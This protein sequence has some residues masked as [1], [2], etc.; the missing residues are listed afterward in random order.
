MMLPKF[1]ESVFVIYLY[2][3]IMMIDISPLFE[4]KRPAISK[5]QFFTGLFLILI[6]I[7]SQYIFPVGGFLY[8][9]IIIYGLPIIIA[10]LFLGRIIAKNAFKNNSKALVQGLAYWGL[11]A[12]AGY[13]AQIIIV[14]WLSGI[15]PGSLALLDR[16]NPRIPAD[17]S[18][19]WAMIPISIFIVGP[20]EEYIFRGFIFGGFLE[21][22]GRKYWFF[23]ALVSSIIFAA[24]HLYYL[25]AFGIA[26]A[27]FFVGIVFVGL[28]LSITYYISKGNLL[29]PVLLHGIFDATGFLSVALQNDSGIN[30][31]VLLA[32][33]GIFIA[34]LLFLKYLAEKIKKAGPAPLCE[35]C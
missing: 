29:V 28:A 11:F 31:Q 35:N 19:L 16:A 17:P 7:Y 15:N 34:I 5:S 2:G 21:T 8:R 18:M 25:T 24:V 22:F 26:S 4:T 32:G 3:K 30:F 10:S 6:L 13:I 27:I 9:M 1:I 14:N 23:W 12:L 33:I 20:A